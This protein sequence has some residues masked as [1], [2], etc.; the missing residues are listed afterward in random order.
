MIRRELAYRLTRLLYRAPMVADRAM[1]CYFLA[2][3]YATPQRIVNFLQV[4]RAY[5]HRTLT[6]PGL[7][8]TI[9]VDPTPL[10]NLRCP[11]C[12]TGRGE[13]ERR[14]GF[15]DMN[16]YRRILDTFAPTAFSIRLWGWGEP[17]LHQGIGEMVAAA[18]ARNLGTEIS[19]NLSVSLNDRD[20][21]RMIE[22]GLDWLTVSCDAATPDT[23]GKYR[24]GGDFHV[25]LDNIRKILQRKRELGSL[26]PFVEW[27]FIPFRHNE[28]EMDRAVSLSREI[29]VDGFRFKPSR[30]DKPG[31]QTF[32]NEVSNEALS[33][34]IPSR[35]DLCHL[36]SPDQKRYH[37]YHCPFLWKSL[38][39]HWNGAIAPCCE[40]FLTGDDVGMF[41]GTDFGDIWNGSTYRRAR[42]LAAG[43]VPEKTGER[44]AC[45][46]CRVFTSGGCG[47]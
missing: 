26:T 29:G 34:W 24:V 5:R 42:S 2:L 13:T 14:S 41:T 8:I 19:T 28:D 46:A 17:L 33:C 1:N 15:M 37:N 18:R 40:T 27:Q 32:T 30:F 4:R 36:T 23:Y 22:G 44:P 43:L 7:P 35:S 38:V 45:G 21:T 6:V 3:C 9:H 12:P 31:D 47:P 10:C 39:I 11:L 20:L 16:L 25:V